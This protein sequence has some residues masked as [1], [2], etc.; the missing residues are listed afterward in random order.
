MGGVGG[1]TY[2]RLCTRMPCHAV[3]CTFARPLGLQ[4]LGIPWPETYQ[5]DNLAVPTEDE[6]PA[7]QIQPDLVA[8]DKVQMRCLPSL[9]EVSPQQVSILWRHKY[10]SS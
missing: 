1:G 5:R 6:S 9:R 3:L 4:R 8:P 2:F 10:S 7:A